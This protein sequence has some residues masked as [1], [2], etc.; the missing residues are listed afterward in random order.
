MVEQGSGN[1][2]L[3]FGAKHFQEPVDAPFGAPRDDPR[4]GGACCGV[5]QKGK[6]NKKRI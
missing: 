6:A 3:D 4:C 2:Q 5:L 1:A